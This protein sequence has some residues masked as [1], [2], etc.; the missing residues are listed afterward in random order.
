MAACT[1]PE[2]ALRNLTPKQG[3]SGSVFAVAVTGTEGKAASSGSNSAGE[4][5]TSLSTKQ[6]AGA[7]SAAGRRGR[8]E[9][10]PKP[11]EPFVLICCAIADASRNTDAPKE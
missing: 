3:E 5:S 9:L 4:A 11:F 1:I 10:W 6:G 8:S 7:G 2:A